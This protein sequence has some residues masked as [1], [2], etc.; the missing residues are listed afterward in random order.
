MKL[1]RIASLGAVVAVSAL[2][3]TACASNETPAG[4]DDTS[5]ATSTSDAPTTDA[6]SGRIVGSGA[7]SQQ[8]AIQSWSQA[9]LAANPD[10]QVEYDPAGSGTGRESF[11]QGAVQFAGSDRAFKIDEIAEGTFSA[12]SDGSGLVEIPAYISPIA[13]IFNLPGIDALDLDAATIAG[14]FAGTITTWNDP[15]I[16]ATNAGVD[17]PATAINPVHRSDK[18]GTTGNFTDYLAATAADV[19]TWGSVEEWP[20]GVVGEAAE[21]TSGVANA[22]KAGEG[23]IGYID[24]SQAEPF[25]SVNVKV[26]DA[27]VGHSAEGAAATLDASAIEDGRSSGDLAFEIDR[28]TT[29]AGA[30][31]VLL[32]SYLIACEQYD[33]ENT[34]ALVRGFFS[35]VVSPEGQDAAAANA[36]SAPISDELRTKSLA[37]IELIK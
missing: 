14:I 31:P 15:A 35:T 27:F 12:C 20:A 2:A 37:A 19:W 16:A 5:S 17:L 9:F 4:G 36:G 13:I 29:A 8:V 32:V 25:S 30:Y 21:K 3:L 10:A 1:N 6:L 28:T 11:Q 22:V 26:G 24:A 34:A 23:S 7:S 18:S 33:D